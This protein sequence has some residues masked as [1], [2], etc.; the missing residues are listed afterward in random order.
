MNKYIMA[1]SFI[2]ITCIHMKKYYATIEMNNLKL[3]ST[4]W[5]DESHKHRLEWKET[6][7]KGQ[8]K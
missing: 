5:M 7:T 8:A 6:D 4:T 3:Y 1:L 2:Y